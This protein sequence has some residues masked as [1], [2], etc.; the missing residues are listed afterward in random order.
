[1]ALSAHLAELNEKH[2]MLDQKIEE[3]SARLGS[4]DAS[5]RRLKQEKLRLKD[6]IVRLSD[7]TKH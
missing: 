4:D 2:R 6:E 1:M 3:E 7:Q 5:I